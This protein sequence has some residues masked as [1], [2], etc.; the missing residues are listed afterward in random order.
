MTPLFK[1]Q[2]RK[3]QG[4]SGKG[5]NWENERELGVEVDTAP[6][7]QKSLYFMLGLKGKIWEME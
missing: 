7:W 3:A 6:C 1:E 2:E 4:L 5:E